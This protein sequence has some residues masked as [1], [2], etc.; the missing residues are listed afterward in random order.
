VGGDAPESSLMF[1]TFSPDG[2]RVAWVRANN[3]YV[4]ELATKKV[5]QLTTD[6]SAD[7]ING[8]SIG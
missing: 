7:I 3:I 8:T 2:S 4:E 1:A 6:G 5:A